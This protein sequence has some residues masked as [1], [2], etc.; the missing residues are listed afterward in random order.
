MDAFVRYPLA[1]DFA[2][3]SSSRAFQRSGRA[4]HLSRDENGGIIPFAD[5][6]V[7]LPEV[8]E[9]TTDYVLIETAT[10][11]PLHAPKDAL[12][13]NERALVLGVIN[14][15]IT[16]P[17]SMPSPA[18]PAGSAAAADRGSHQQAPSFELLMRQLSDGLRPSTRDVEPSAARATAAP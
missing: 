10:R 18:P 14:A 2:K 3:R 7:R 9:V 16:K 12:D 11:R 4:E 1:A 15:V 8:F 6:I 17:N 5:G 13:D